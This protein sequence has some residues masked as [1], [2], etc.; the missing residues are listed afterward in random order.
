M[1]ILMCLKLFGDLC[2]YFSVVG[3]FPSLFFHSFSLL[4]PAVLCGV[5]TGMAAFASERGKDRLRFL[6][7]LLP[8]SAFLLCGSWMDLLILLPAVI[9][10]GAVIIR[11]SLALEYYGQRQFFLRSLVAWAIFFVVIC[12][13]QH[14]ESMTLVVPRAL[15]FDYGT[16]LVYGLL[17][18][19][20]Q[21]VLLLRLRMGE[22]EAQAG[23]LHGAQMAGVLTATGG[24][25]LAAVGLERL[26]LERGTSLLGQLV[27]VGWTLFSLLTELI[28]LLFKGEQKE[29]EELLEERQPTDPTFATNPFP[30]GEGT[31]PVVE[32]SKEIAFPW[33]LAVFILLALLAVLLYMLKTFH[34]ACGGGH[35]EEKIQALSPQDREEKEVRR[36]NR[37][38]VRRSY[39]AFLKAEKRKGLKLRTDQTSEDILH[40]L[41]ENTDRQ[42]AAQLRQVYL[43]ARYDEQHPVTQEQ[44]KEARSAMRKTR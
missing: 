31:A 14:F 26:L 24:F 16:A 37:E 29:L 44:V 5:G 28:G 2:L 15:T 30:T 18:G 38:K 6:G 43:R 39:R 40:S 21:V 23:K 11:G 20:A 13:L 1:S 25:L 4:W 22:E 34:T 9:Y 3:A 8:A 36:T 17:Y 10:T 35:T 33:W 27:K 12:L 7:L 41:G 19:G 42:A 32:E